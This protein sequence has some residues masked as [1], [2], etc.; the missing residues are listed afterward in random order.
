MGFPGKAPGP[1]AADTEWDGGL[2]LAR[3][4][5]ARVETSFPG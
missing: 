5:S 1:R 2:V 3:G 4:C